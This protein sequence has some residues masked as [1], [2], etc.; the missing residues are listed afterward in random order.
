MQPHV[1]DA[2]L[3]AFRSV[4]KGQAMAAVFG[5]SGDESS[6]VLHSVLPRNSPFAEFESLFPDNDIRWAVLGVRYLTKCKG[7]RGKLLWVSWAPDTLRRASFRES[8]RVKSSA[9]SAPSSFLSDIRADLSTVMQANRPDDL[10]SA[11]IFERASRFERDEI[12]R[13]SIAAF[14]DGQLA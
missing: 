13:D 10:S 11:N 6:I 7:I 14:V 9:L 5:L 8:A 12:D 3:S 4:K 2:C 1:D